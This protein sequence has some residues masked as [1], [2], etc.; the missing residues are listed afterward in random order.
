M[1]KFF[2]KKNLTTRNNYSRPPDLPECSVSVTKLK[3]EIENGRRL[4][5]AMRNNHVDLVALDNILNGVSDK[6]LYL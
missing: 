6:G 2:F 5:T 4:N 1:F 3:E